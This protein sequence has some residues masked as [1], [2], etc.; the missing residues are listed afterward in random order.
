MDPNQALQ[1]AREALKEVRRIDESAG[2]VTVGS[3]EADIVKS[4]S[5]FITATVAL[6]DAF[7]ALD[8]WLSVGGFLPQ[9]W[10]NASSL[11]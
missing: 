3:M 8:N 5:E 9:D 7:E 4:A 1:D 6:A 10:H 11:D 2:T